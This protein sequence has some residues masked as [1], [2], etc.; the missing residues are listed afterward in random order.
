MYCVRSRCHDL[1]F[2]NETVTTQIY[3]YCNLLS[4]PYA[5]PICDGEF[6]RR[7][8]PGRHWPPNPLHPPASSPR[9]TASSSAPK[10]TKSL[11]LQFTPLSSNRI[12]IGRAHV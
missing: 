2:I 11:A 3:T 5:L 10:T 8:F 4:L 6:P 1:F 12:E 7:P 9:Q